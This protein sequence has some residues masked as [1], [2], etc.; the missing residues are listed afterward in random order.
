M[1]VIV[2]VKVAQMCPTLSDPMDCNPQGSSVHG[3][4]QARI[5]E[6]WPFP[7]QGDLPNSGIKPSSPELQADSLSSDPPG[8]LSGAHYRNSGIYICIFIYF[9]ILSP[10]TLNCAISNI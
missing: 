1:K 9:Q 2:N 10:Y 8:K 6:W 3:N 5:L 7:S 4:L